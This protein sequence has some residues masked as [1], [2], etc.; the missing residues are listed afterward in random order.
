MKQIKKVVLEEATRLSQEEMKQVFG[1]SGL[2]PAE[3][4]ERTCKLG[5]KCKVEVLSGSQGNGN[6]T[7][8]TGTC[9]GDFISGSVRC[10]CEVVGFSYTPINLSHCYKGN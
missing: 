1:G 9:Q 7:V 10:Y 4:I 2:T 3:L 6:N 8:Y 5:T